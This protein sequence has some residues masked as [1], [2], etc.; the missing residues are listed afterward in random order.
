MVNQAD[1][2]AFYGTL[3]L[4]MENFFPYQEYIKFVKTAEIAG[5]KMYSLGEYPYI[6]R[7]GREKDTIVCDLCYIRN[8]W[9]GREIDVMEIEAGYACENIEMDGQTFRIF[10]YKNYIPGTQGIQS[11][12]WVRLIGEMRY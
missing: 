8:S 6:V 12:D 2:Y 7:T 10:V 5:F 1:K 3:R 4:K 11:G 9:V